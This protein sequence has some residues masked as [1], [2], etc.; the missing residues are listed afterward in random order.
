LTEELKGTFRKYKHINFRDESLKRIAMVNEIIKPY[1]GALSV[2]QIHYQFVS[3]FPLMYANTTENYDNLVKL[4][5]NGRLNGLIAW[6]AI[7]DRNRFLQGV[8]F[9]RNPFEAVRATERSYKI[10]LWADQ[11]WRPEVWVEKA[12]LEGVISEVCY[13]LRV[14][15]LS[16]RGYNSQSMAWEA[17]QRFAGYIRNGQRPIMFH[18]GDFDPSGR[19]MT[20]DNRERIEL[21]TGVPVLVQRLALNMDQ[22][23]RYNPPPNPAK[24]T[25]ARFKQYQLETGLDESFEVDALEPSVLQALIRDAVMRIRDEKKWDALLEQEVQ[26]RRLIDDMIKAFASEGEDD[27]SP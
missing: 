8:Q 3:R 4:I 26:D 25:D 11:E 21:F 13:D 6:D 10:D 15:F 14:N 2:R 17:G 5:S 27:G 12:S 22:I 9:W 18:V 16:L 1:D 7:E 19:D 24:K 23:E 20:R